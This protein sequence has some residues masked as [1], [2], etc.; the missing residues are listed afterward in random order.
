MMTWAEC[1]AAGMSQREAA[2]ARQ[3][4]VAA[5]SIAAK[6]LGLTFRPVPMKEALNRPDVKERHRAAMKEALNRPE[7]KERRSAAIKEAMNRPE[8]KERHREAIKEAMNRP[9]IKE[10][11]RAAMNR[12]DVNPLVLLTPTERADYDLLKRAGHSR[13]D[14]LRSIGRGDLIR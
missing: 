4:S 8:I 7:V 3:V 10:Q 1:A 14:A 13:N 2:E 6:R 12:P 5:A 9:E 11:R